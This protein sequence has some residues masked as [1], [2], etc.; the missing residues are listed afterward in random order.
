ML[1]TTEHQVLGGGGRGGDVPCAQPEAVFD[2]NDADIDQ[3]ERMEVPD[4]KRC[5]VRG[6]ASELRRSL[7][8]AVAG[9]SFVAMLGFLAD[10]ALGP[11]IGGGASGSCRSNTR[12]SCPLAS[13]SASRRC[14]S[15]WRS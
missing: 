3:S 6:K 4:L 2:T 7:E 14:D 10:Q 1:D 15:H 9:L 12:N 5:L 8:A 13:S 11:R